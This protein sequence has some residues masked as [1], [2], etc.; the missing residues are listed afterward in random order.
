MIRTP[1]L[2]SARQNVRA[3]SVVVL[4]MGALA[5]TGC[6]TLRVQ[7]LGAPNASLDRFHTFRIMEAPPN[8]DGKVPAWANEPMLNNSITYQAGREFL[9][10]SLEARGFV[11]TRTNPD[12]NVA[13][14]ASARERLNITNWGYG[15]GWNNYITEYTE[16]TVI[17]DIVDP[18]SR[19]LLWRGR[20]VAT[21]SDNPRK[22]LKEL[23]RI[24]PRIVDRLPPALP[25]V[26]AVDGG[27]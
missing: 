19:K 24:V 10:R 25:A 15:Y 3:L 2:A 21:V 20:G 7:T 14:Y 1:L 18:D 4:V 22:Y 11:E 23:S 6:S 12:F 13:F 16:G 5:T 26:V 8:L 17:I 9:K 27:E